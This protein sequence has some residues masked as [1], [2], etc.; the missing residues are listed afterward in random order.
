[1]NPRILH[2]SLNEDLDA[3]LSSLISLVVLDLGGP[4][5]FGAY[6]VDARSFRVDCRIAR[7]TGGWA[8]EGSIVVVEVPVRVGNKS[9]EVV[10]AVYAIVGGLEK[11]R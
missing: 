11:D 4:G 10:D 8:F 7:L 2:N 9:P 1:M 6:V 5:S 3:M